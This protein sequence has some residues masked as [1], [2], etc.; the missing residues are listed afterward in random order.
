MRYS[1]QCREWATYPL[2]R[3][4]FTVSNNWRRFLKSADSGFESPP[5]KAS[6]ASSDSDVGGD[7][8][9]EKESGA[10]VAALGWAERG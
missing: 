2:L 8:S 10:M 1:F 4:A 9:A 3:R 7:E 6:G 5:S